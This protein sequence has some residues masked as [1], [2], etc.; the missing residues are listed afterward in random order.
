[1]IIPV[2]CFTCNAVISSKYKE[3]KRLTAIH[4]TNE[5]I[6]TL[7]DSGKI[8]EQIEINKTEILEKIGVER[9]CCTRHL[10]THVDLVYKI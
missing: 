8:N 5:D 2:R 3:Y 4:A 7:V 10:L 9:M 1:M 6:I